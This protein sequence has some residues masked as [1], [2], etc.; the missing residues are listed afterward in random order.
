MR[1]GLTAE[2]GCARARNSI[3]PHGGRRGGLWSA[4]VGEDVATCRARVSG[5]EGFRGPGPAVRAGGRGGA[6]GVSPRPVGGI[7]HER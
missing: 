5:A 4:K 6:G 2:P 7:R 1:V 3:S